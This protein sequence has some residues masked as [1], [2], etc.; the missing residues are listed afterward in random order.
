MGWLFSCD[1][2]FKKADQIKKF[3]EP[4]YWSEGYKL[5]AD[6]VV[7]NRYW[8]AIQS[9]DGRKF[10]FLALMQSGGRD[11]GWGYK[12]M[13]EHSGPYYHDCPLSLLEMTDEPTEGY[14]AE[15]RKR[16]RTHH[17]N[18]KLRVKPVEGQLV[19][20]GD[21]TYRLLHPWAPRKGWRVIDVSTGITYRMSAR[22]LSA[23][24]QVTEVSA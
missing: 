22:Q 1:P 19:K 8:A 6:R 10:I 11:T 20:Y 18:K 5:I 14:A 21:A 2:S 9:A 16:V 3:R 7:G 17:E 12:D 24:K 4:S 15:W 23:A 13:T